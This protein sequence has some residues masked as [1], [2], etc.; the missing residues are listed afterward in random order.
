MLRGGMLYGQGKLTVSKAGVYF[1]YSQ[2][3]F[4]NSSL[5]SL[6]YYVCVNDTVKAMGVRTG[7]QSFN[8][9]SHSFLVF[10]NAFDFITVKLMRNDI[11]ADLHEKA[12]FFGAFLV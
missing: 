3:Y 6:I 5:K 4:T 2:I 9:V 12:S 1:V 7:R 10:L 8:T 11:Y